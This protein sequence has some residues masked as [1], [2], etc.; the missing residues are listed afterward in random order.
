MYLGWVGVIYG[1]HATNR[2][3]AGEGCSHR[4]SSLLTIGH[5]GIIYD[6]QLHGYALF[7]SHLDLR[8]ILFRGLLEE[9]QP[10]VFWKVQGTYVYVWYLCVC[11]F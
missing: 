8:L 2:N 6:S 7:Y 1:F 11:V 10:R 5:L 3:V 9:V 4:E